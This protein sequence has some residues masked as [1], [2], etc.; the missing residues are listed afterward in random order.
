MDSF[1]ES[2]HHYEYVD[3]FERTSKG[4]YEGTCQWISKN[5]KFTEW[6]LSGPE[7]C[8]ILWIQGAPGLGKSTLLTYIVQ[9]VMDQRISDW[10]ISLPSLS[11]PTVVYSFCNSQT[12]NTASLVMS[13]AIH[14][15]LIRFP[16]IVPS[17][18]DFNKSRSTNPKVG[19][20]DAISLKRKSP[21]QLWA[22]FQ[23]LAKESKANII[24]VVDGLNECDRDSQQALLELLI[25]TEGNIKILISS[26]PD[27]Q[28]I[29]TLSKW[30]D[31]SKGTL[32]YLNT[33]E[34]Q[35]HINNDIDRYVQ[36]EISRISDH[37]GYSKSQKLE[38]LE[39][40]KNDR[41]GLF[42]PVVLMLKRLEVTP[43]THL[44][45]VLKDSA[46]LLAKD[47]DHTYN[48]L[49]REMPDSIR[50]QPSAVFKYL[51]YAHS[52]LTVRDLAL[53]CSSGYAGSKD[54]RHPVLS[55]SFIC[56][57]R[58]D[59][60]LYGPILRVRQDDVVEFVHSSAKEYLLVLSQAPPSSV[61]FLTP[62][63]QAHCEIAIDCLDILISNSSLPLEEPWGQWRDNE[64][65]ID[66]K[67]L[68]PYALQHWYKHL[69]DATS[70]FTSVET[71]DRDIF[72][73]VREL[74]NLWLNDSTRSF[75]GILLER[76]GL[77]DN[78][79][80]IQDHIST[81][82]VFSG[83]GLSLFVE[84]LLATRVHSL[85][86]NVKA[87]LALAIK[88]G[89]E[90]T[91]DILT[92][93]FEMTVLE[94][95]EFKR[96]IDD[97][98]RSGQIN[99]LRKMVRMRKQEASEY[100]SALVG[101]F[102]S[103]KREI[104]DTLAYEMGDFKTR[105]LLGLTVIHRL[106]ARPFNV[107]L[108]SQT[109]L[110]IAQYL[111]SCGADINDQDSWGN[112]ALHYACQSPCLSNPE[113][114]EGLLRLHAD[115][116][117]RNSFGWTP[118]HLAARYTKYL[119]SIKILLQYGGPGLI[120]AKT[121]SGR[122]PLGFACQRHDASFGSHDYNVV[123]NLALQGANFSTIGPEPRKRW[124][125]TEQYIDSSNFCAL[126][127]SLT[128]NP[129]NT[130]T[131]VS[132][133]ANMTVVS[134][135]SVSTSPHTLVP[136]PADFFRRRTPIAVPFDGDSDTESNLSYITAPESP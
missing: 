61:K 66:G 31:I 101:A 116:W 72:L 64:K 76:C 98:A 82:Q 17:G 59:L 8:N 79:Q 94:G 62:Q 113:L 1:V 85:T 69:R 15:L 13:I 91:V 124:D 44:T 10:R 110:A 125:L 126:D 23:H 45:R 129:A 27:E 21:K 50:S 128:G 6:Y 78:A 20:D 37:R 3:D 43:A 26:R 99:L 58:H 109:A 24:F 53:A 121:N 5:A 25:Q 65:I 63:I 118:F 115:L 22:L 70:H 71:I 38:I 107:K 9:S 102:S 131:D 56:S 11:T 97:A 84:N 88:G 117:R 16:S 132:S 122:T 112:T 52:P 133:L 55:D 29:I 105:D 135:A 77:Y 34:E 81:L 134:L 106:F 51:M 130:S 4:K 18:Y 86:P 28:L 49:L 93:H 60:K 119:S 89:H 108:A 41:S 2:F 75:R 54:E 57:F 100:A 120:E 96:A 42:L 103:G 30:L 111:V 80:E 19:G 87:A 114:I 90:L 47:L 92:N 67:I 73:R 127:T 123:Q 95:P 36:V 12:N 39:V 32:K 33:Q 35:H 83:L 46:K 7:G 136:G 74:A 40:L 14:Q 48:K 104:L 68:L